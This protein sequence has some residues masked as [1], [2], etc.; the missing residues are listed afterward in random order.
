MSSAPF[1]FPASDQERKATLQKI[2][3]YNETIDFV[4]ADV[5]LGIACQEFCRSRD[6]LVDFAI[7]QGL[8]PYL[9]RFLQRCG[10]LDDDW[11]KR[12]ESV[13]AAFQRIVN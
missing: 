1:R 3:L 6:D 13:S 7:R 9:Q 5:S 10:W 4:T 2:G 11:R 8:I 12:L